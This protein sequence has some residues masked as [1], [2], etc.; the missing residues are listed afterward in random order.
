MTVEPPAD[1][2]K[3]ANVTVHYWAAAKNAAGIGEEMVQAPT[4]ADLIDQI[5]R[6]HADKARFDDVIGMCSILIGEIPVG[7]RDH[8]TVVL[9]EGDTIEFLPPFAGG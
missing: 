3:M 9:S 6:R 7:A 5:L 8:G 4:L 2:Q 1:A